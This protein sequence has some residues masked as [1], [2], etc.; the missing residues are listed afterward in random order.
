VKAAADDRQGA[1]RLIID[2]ASDER[3]LVRCV[4]A[5]MTRTM[6]VDMADGR[7]IRGRF[8]C[9]DQLHNIILAGAEERIAR[10]G[11]APISVCMGL[12]IVPREAVVRVRVR[13]TEEELDSS[14][15]G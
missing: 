8:E 15:R 13:M 1:G 14:R 7:E 12:V 4:R 11:A 9:F 2:M 5:M 3:E 10:E 6:I